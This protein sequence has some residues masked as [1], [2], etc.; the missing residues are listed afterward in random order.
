MGIIDASLN[1]RGAFAGKAYFFR[2]DRYVRYDWT[3]DRVDDGYPQP[4]S[5]WNLPGKFANGID[6][7]LNGEAAFIGKAYF[8]RGTRYVRYDWATDQVEGP[9]PSS[10]W[11]LSAWN[12][13]GEFAS[14]IDAA[15]NGQGAFTGKAYFFRENQYARY[16][17]ATNQVDIVQS[18]S[19][20]NLPGEFAS[21]IDAA[22][23]G[24]G[25]YIGKAYFFRGDQ[26]VRY[27]WA[28]NQIDNGPVPII[29]NWKGMERL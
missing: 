3:S 22:L 11:N 24:E 29:G 1:G 26:Y 20:W 5:A 17:W 13:P 2:A 27:D 15:L 6:T 9:Q 23:N 12:L 7:A 19:A 21:G 28:T 16:D 25:A 18:V 8:F 10:A 14:G 4:L